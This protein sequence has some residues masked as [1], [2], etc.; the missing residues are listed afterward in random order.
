MGAD[1]KAAALFSSKREYDINY[2]AKKK[3]KAKGRK[4]NTSHLWTHFRMTAE[5]YD[6]ILES[7]GGGCAICG[8]P[9]DAYEDCYVGG[10]RRLAVDHDH[11]CCPG[12]RSYGDCNRG[13]LCHGCNIGLGSFQDTPSR[14]LSAIKYLEATSRVNARQPTSEVNVDEPVSQAHRRTHETAHQPRHPRSV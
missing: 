4:V 11:A 14:M 3:A 9:G 10:A 8:A 12:S 1:R 13:L 7:Q 6:A 2:R 5:D